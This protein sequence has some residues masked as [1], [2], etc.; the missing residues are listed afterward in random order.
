MMAQQTLPPGV[1]PRG[2][3][4]AQAAEYIGVSSTLFD[5]MVRDRRMPLPRRINARSVWDVRQ[6]DEAFAALPG[7]V[8]N[9][10]T[11]EWDDM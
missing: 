4:R 5:A 7:D 6:V 8:G 10:P 9:E 2:L 11:N 1:I 3:S